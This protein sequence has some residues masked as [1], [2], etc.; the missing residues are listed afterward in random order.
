L[1][2]WGT[3][4]YTYWLLKIGVTLHQWPGGV[5][6]GNV[7]IDQT[8]RNFRGILPKISWL[9]VEPYPSEK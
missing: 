8:P 5:D 3:T 9:V 1:A 6:E 7:A 4:I 2:N